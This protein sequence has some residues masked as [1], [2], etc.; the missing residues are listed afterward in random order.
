MAADSDDITKLEEFLDKLPG[1]P[2]NKPEQKMLWTVWARLYPEEAMT[3]SEMG[4]K[5]PTIKMLAKPDMDLDKFESTVGMMKKKMMET[6]KKK[7]LAQLE[8]KKA[9]KKPEMVPI[10]MELFTA[11]MEVEPLEVE[12]IIEDE[13]T[14]KPRKVLIKKPSKK[15][16]RKPVKVTKPKKSPLSTK[17]AIK[18]VPKTKTSIKAKKA[19]K[20]VTRDKATPAAKPI[21]KAVP[22]A[23][24]PIKATTTKSEKKNVLGKK[25]IIKAKKSISKPAK[26]VV[27]PAKKAIKKTMKKQV[28]K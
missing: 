13:D 17:T 16:I 26:K 25:G 3:H 2:S 27:K 19:G 15:T 6:I 4:I 18:P 5:I 21:K 9:E 11:P 7:K 10:K 8:K 24:K 22:K 12:P 1:Q 23:K 14:E 28:K 20:P